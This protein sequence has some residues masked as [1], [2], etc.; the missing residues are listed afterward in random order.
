[1]VGHQ[2]VGQQSDGE[3]LVDLLDRPLERGVVL[4]LVKEGG[5]SDRAVEDVVNESAAANASS[6]G[7]GGQ[8]SDRKGGRS[9]GKTPDPFGPA[10]G[11][12]PD[13]FACGP[14]C[15]RDPFACDP[16]GPAREGAE[17]TT[18]LLDDLR[19]AKQTQITAFSPRYWDMWIEHIDDAGIYRM[20]LPLVTLDNATFERRTR[21]PDETPQDDRHGYGRSSAL[22]VFHRYPLPT[23]TA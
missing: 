13:P 20:H 16:F 10:S 3:T 14:L 17:L 9:S 21:L 8:D 7:H 18:A 11:K 1:V 2:T 19:D 4:R 5:P 22:N 15:L 23:F 12:I 6:P